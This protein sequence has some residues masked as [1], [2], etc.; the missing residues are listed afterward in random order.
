MVG[1]EGGVGFFAELEVAVEHREGVFKE[2]GG[3]GLVVGE[4]LVEGA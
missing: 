2:V 4:D 3:V 1:D